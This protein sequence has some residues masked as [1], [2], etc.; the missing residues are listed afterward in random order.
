MERQG[1]EINNNKDNKE[2]ER[3]T[4][5][6]AERISTEGGLEVKKGDKETLGLPDRD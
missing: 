1:R 2:R 4:P 5:E 3:Y 6:Y